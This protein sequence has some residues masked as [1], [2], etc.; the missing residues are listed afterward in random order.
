[1]KPIKDAIDASFSVSWTH[2][3]RFTNSVFKENG[4]LDTLLLELNPPQILVVL[5]SGLVTA[6]QSFRH[7]LKEWCTQA[8]LVCSEPIVVCGGE[9]A[10]NDLMAV[11]QVLDAINTNNLCR[12]SCVLAIFI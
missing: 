10:K 12:K 2:K 7:A 5:D 6:N 11:A 9:S 3:L 4:V 8:D 1:M